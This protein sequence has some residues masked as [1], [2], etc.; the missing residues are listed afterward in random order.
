MKTQGLHH[1]SM[2]V[3]DFDATVKLYTEGFGFTQEAAW[4]MNDGRQAI[5]LN[6]GDG[7]CLEVFSGGTAEEQPAGIFGHIAL[8]SEDCDGDYA[9]ALAAGAKKDMEPT[10]VTLPTDP[11]TKIRIAFCKGFDGER[12]EFFQYC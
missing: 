7:S 1:V 10:D 12:I 5:M 2:T 8:A 4:T 6:M 11:P 3:H 9:K